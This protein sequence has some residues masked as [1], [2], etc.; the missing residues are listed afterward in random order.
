MEWREH[1]RARGG[2]AALTRGLLMAACFVIIVSGL[3]A[4]RSVL[5]PVLVAAFIAVVT[6]PLVLWMRRHR[7]PS[8]VAVLAVVVIILSVAVGLGAIIGTSLTDFARRLPFYQSAL[9]REVAELIAALQA[10]GLTI[11]EGAQDGAF[12]P[13]A[14][15]GLAA[16]LLNSLRGLLTNGLLILLTVVF[17]LLEAAGFE[18]KLRRALSNPEATLRRYATFAYNAKQYLVVKTLVSVLTGT[19]VA[20]LVAAMGVSYPLLWG[21]LAFLLNYIPTIGSII[22]SIPAVLLAVVEIGLAGAVVLL[23]GYVAINIIMG[24]LIEPRWAGREVGLSPLVVFLSLV[25]WGWILGPVGL[26]LAVPLTMTVKLAFESNPQ[27]QGIAI[28]LGPEKVSERL[29]DDGALENAS[30]TARTRTVP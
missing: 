8:G 17:I 3:Q 16:L 20:V 2:G 15:L 1:Q 22:A 27:T 19:F 26:L 23:A 14:A 7:V 10:R 9:S 12:G 28:L 24:N 21:L 25:F 29:G 4:A 18:A 30:D 11:P 6:A 5:V 13:G